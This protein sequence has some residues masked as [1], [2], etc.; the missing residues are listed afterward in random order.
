MKLLR[1][2][3][4]LSLLLGAA[5]AAEARPHPVR[6]AVKKVGAKAKKVL[7]RHPVRSAIHRLRHR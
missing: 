7:K 2:L 6:A 5:G 1:S 4:V 3:L